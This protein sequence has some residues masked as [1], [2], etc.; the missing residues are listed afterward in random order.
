MQNTHLTNDEELQII[1]DHRHEVCMGHELPPNTCNNTLIP[2]WALHYMLVYVIPTASFSFFERMFHTLKLPTSGAWSR[3]AACWNRVDILDFL[4]KNDYGPYDNLDIVA[5]LHDNKEMYEFIH[6]KQL[7]RYKTEKLDDMRHRHLDACARGGSVE[8]LQL[9]FEKTND[10]NS[11][12]TMVDADIMC[13]L[14]L[15]ARVDLLTYIDNHNFFNWSKVRS[16][17]LRCNLFITL[18]LYS[19][20]IKT[21]KYLTL[22]KNISIAPELTLSRVYR[23]FP[24][25]LSMMSGTRGN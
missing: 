16:D 15:N 9:I 23:V 24:A 8:M 17:A 22:E 21:L 4:I 1:W 10:I 14:L 18:A 13:L 2:K 20:C 12:D 5:I 11:V 25:D 3:T 6:S 19:K 7:A